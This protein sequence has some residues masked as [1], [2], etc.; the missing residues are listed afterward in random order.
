MP[1]S[2]RFEPFQTLHDP[3]LEEMRDASARFT[4][5]MLDLAPARWLSLLGTS[6]AGK[7]MLAQIVTR[8]F[9]ERC[10]GT[11]DE[12]F[13]GTGEVRRKKGGF[14]RWKDAINRMLGGD[15]E[16][17]DDLRSRWFFV[18][19]DIAAESDNDRVRSLSASKLY[20]VLES[21]L[22]KWTVITANRSLEFIG[23]S[24][25][26]RIASRMLRGGSVV[27]DVDVKDFN[28]R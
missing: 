4:Q 10:D 15:Y 20:D 12:S 26:A 16:F 22:G 7:T 3:Q 18:L 24:L 1:V 27:I 21:R 17:L 23:R 13:V 14:I 6:G 5:D 25:D 11:L 28:L 9:R 8:A 19:D 2:A